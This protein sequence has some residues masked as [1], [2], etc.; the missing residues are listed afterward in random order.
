MIK[1]NTSSQNNHSKNRKFV[2][3]SILIATPLV[4]IFAFYFASIIFPRNPEHWSKLGDS[5][6]GIFGPIIEYITLMAF[7][8]TMYMQQKQ[9]DLYS[10]ELDEAK[11]SL[12]EAQNIQKEQLKIM[13][14]QQLDT[15]LMSYIKKLDIEVNDLSSRTY[16]YP[17]V[18]KAQFNAQYP[19]K[20]PL[21]LS[22]HVDHL[23]TTF[24]DTPHDKELLAKDLSKFKIFFCLIF[25]ILKFINTQLSN[26]SNGNDD[27]GG[28]FLSENPSRCTLEIT[29]TYINLIRANLKN[30]FMLLLAINGLQEKPIGESGDAGTFK[31][32]IELY[33]F[34]EFMDKD[35]NKFCKEFCS[36][37]NSAFGEDKE[38]H[39]NLDGYRKKNK[40]KSKS[41]SKSKSIAQHFFC[42]QHHCCQHHA[43]AGH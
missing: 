30:E 13:K 22:Q 41:K 27:G 10:Q 16:D 4:M 15:L 38:F 17:T 12:R 31:K 25:D 29:Q 8:Y 19:Y 26:P 21:T 18:Y 28:E 42:C 39:K 33:S 2:R 1:N 23:G 24:R 40:I 35:M 32:L 36:Y 43:R 11:K 37:E 34:L 5:I 6:G 20:A 7:L 3:I 9:L 14:I